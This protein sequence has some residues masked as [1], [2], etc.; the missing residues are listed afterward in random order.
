MTTTENSR[1]DALTDAE[2]AMLVDVKKF[3]THDFGRGPELHA[4]AI[5]DA[6]KR[7][8][9]ASPVE[10]PAAAPIPKLKPPKY[11]V[12]AEGEIVRGAA[13]APADERAAFEMSDD[14]LLGLQIAYQKLE[15]IASGLTYSKDHDLDGGMQKATI[16]DAVVHA[17]YALERFRPCF[18]SLGDSYRKQR[19]S[20]RQDTAARA[21]SASETGAEAAIIGAWRTE[22][23]RAISAE[24]KDGMLR[25]GGAGA[26]SVR[27]Y[28][29]PCYLGSPAMAAEAVAIPGGW[30]LVPKEL[31]EDM[32]ATK[33]R[34][35]D[36]DM[37]EMWKEL[38]DAAP[39][40]PA[41]ADAL[42]GLGFRIERRSEID[43]L[44]YD[45]ESCH[46]ASTEEVALWN[47]IA[48]HP[49]QP[50]PR[51]EVTD[52]ELASLLPGTYYM[53]PPDGGNVSLLEQLRRMADDAA[54]YRAQ[55]TD[56]ARAVLAERRR[57]IEREGWTPKHD[58][59]HD[60]GELVEAAACYALHGGDPDP[61][62]EVPAGWPW[63]PD[64]WKPASERRN[65]VKAGALI[66]AEIERLDRCA[67][68]AG[69]AS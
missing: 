5:A 68:H 67:A 65:L 62:E 23:G 53:D 61:R 66:L 26:S 59:E 63:D 52:A 64:W 7:G 35:G 17:K 13:P 28:S 11:H 37:W 60:C 1:A 27:P 22:D 19:F 56:A 14:D 43:V 25:D 9:A 32:V 12:D 46:P 36:V 50:E 47:V 40:P 21:A 58:D 15:L 8:R 24:Q 54:L 48:A 3:H 42:E 31:T 49:G 45:D 16:R 38:L 33:R 69:D 39:Q 29:I 20:R 6:Y 57:Q 34:L 2:A 55:N 51:A 10:Q 41:Q 30:Q 4:D 18:F 44:V